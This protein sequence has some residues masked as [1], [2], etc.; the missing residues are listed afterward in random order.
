MK[1]RSCLY[2]GYPHGERDRIAFDPVRERVWTLCERCHGWNL[3]WRDERGVTLEALERLCR[4]EARVVYQT[5]HIALLDAGDSQ[6]VR[7]G[8]APRR[9]EAWWRYGR[10]LRR[11]H[12]RFLSPVTAV[13]AATYTAVSRVGRAVGFESVTG[14]FRHA[15]DR[16]AEILRWRRFGGTA[17]SGRA[18]CPH[19][20]SVLI[21]L[22]FFKAPDLI[23]MPGGDGTGTV[24]G[25]A[26]GMPCT[27]CDPWTVEKTYQFDAT[28]AQPLLRR[29]LAWHN[30][31][32][33]T[34]AELSRAV[35]RIEEAGS[36]RD[37]VDAVADARLSLHAL[38]RIDR[39][40]LEV[41]VNERA[42]RERLELDMAV[43]EAGWRRADEIAG[44]IEEELDPL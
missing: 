29:V 17:W 5:D 7:V 41:A 24:E 27:R 6:L 4:D 20:S 33:G 11:R 2:C 15:V 12:D 14:D 31:R 26:I 21:R 36:A 30:I 32:G 19:C 28:T 18:P 35:E 22:F 38:Q 37:F 8:R 40:A 10:H 44:I 16:R 43:L 42:E 25:A 39:L 9:E 1:P 13:A 23:L 3:W 34:T